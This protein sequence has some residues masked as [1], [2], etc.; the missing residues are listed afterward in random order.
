MV[1]KHMWPKKHHQWQWYR[2]KTCEDENV[3]SWIWANKAW[4]NKCCKTCGTEWS[5]AGKEDDGHENTDLDDC[6]ADDSRRVKKQKKTQAA[7]LVDQDTIVTLS[8][9]AI[10]EDGLQAAAC[11]IKVLAH[12]AMNAPLWVELEATC[13]AYI[14]AA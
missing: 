14:R 5:E 6:N 8:M 7:A 1:A 11:N 2:C 10:D 3:L 12:V 13:L 4:K 9:P